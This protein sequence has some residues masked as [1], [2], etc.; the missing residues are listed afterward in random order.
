[1]QLFEQGTGSLVF[2]GTTDLAGELDLP[3]LVAGTTYDV[4]CTTQKRRTPMQDCGSFVADD[5]AALR[6]LA[7]VLTGAQNL[8]LYGHVAL[9]SGEVCGHESAFFGIRSA[10]TVQLPRQRRRGDRL[11]VH[12]N[13]FGDYQLSA[14][15]PVTG[16]LTLDVQC[17]GYAAS[18]PCPPR[19]TR[20]LR[21][22]RA[23]RALAR[24]RQCPAAARPG[25]SPTA[26]TATSAARWSCRATAP[27]RRSIPAPTT[28]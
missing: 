23:D 1:V 15:V 26:P 7:P 16:A 12:V 24:D 22:E 2:G 21:G 5:E 11:A 25:W 18:L 10:A 27:A 3:K 17:E 13:R 14:A 28:T 4:R 6:N 9:A 8:R 19:P 20:G